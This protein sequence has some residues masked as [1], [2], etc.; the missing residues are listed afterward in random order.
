MKAAICLPIKSS[1]LLY[2][3]DSAIHIYFPDK[4][5]AI[6]QRKVR[7]FRRWDHTY[8]F[9]FGSYFVLFSSYILLCRLVLPF[10]FCSVV[11][12]PFKW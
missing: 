11:V 9:I 8:S 6:A 7:A 3:F 10:Q 4:I 1:L 12:I 2:F 5:A